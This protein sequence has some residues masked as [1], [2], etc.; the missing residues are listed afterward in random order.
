MEVQLIT[1]AQ[2]GDTDA[3]SELVRLYSRRVYRL[4][5]SFLHNVDDASDIVQ[6]VFLRAYRSL[7]RFDTSRAFYP[8]LHRITRNLCIN[9][10]SLKANTEGT[11]PVEELL[12]AAGYDPLATTL[13]NEELEQLRIAVTNLPEM[14]REIIVLKHFQECSYAEIAEILDVPIG[15]V[16]S[17]LYNARQKLK[18]LL[19]EA[20]V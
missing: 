10:R 13:R 1:A 5:Y 18:A 12:P 7:A 15:T 6:E 11:L 20:E 3:F 14:H 8:W 4:A 16:M 2:A 9:R 19:T 17:R